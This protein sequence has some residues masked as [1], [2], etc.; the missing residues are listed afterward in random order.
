M[1]E[2]ESEK[3]SL[4]VWW[5]SYSSSHVINNLVN[6]IHSLHYISVSILSNCSIIHQHSLMLSHPVSNRRLCTIHEEMESLVCLLLSSMYRLRHLT[7]LM[8]IHFCFFFYQSSR[9]LAAEAIP[10]PRLVMDLLLV[11]ALVSSLICIS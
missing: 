6:S 11:P 5:Q 10:P 9:I 3:A 7:K 1:E 4:L 8:Y 2:S